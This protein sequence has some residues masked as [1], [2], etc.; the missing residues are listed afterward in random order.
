[1]KYLLYVTCSLG[2]LAGAGAGGFYQPGRSGA[3]SL[4]QW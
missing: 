4:Y 1:M 3:S 2:T